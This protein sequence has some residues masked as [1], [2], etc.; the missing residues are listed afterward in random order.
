M[1]FLDLVW[2]GLGVAINKLCKKDK[3]KGQTPSCTKEKS[4]NELQGQGFYF[5]TSNV[6]L[7][8]LSNFP[9]P[10]KLSNLPNFIDFQNSQNFL[11]S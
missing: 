6:K 2:L 10:P 4:Q 7:S 5:G 8:K 3:H 11:A 9:N 1:G